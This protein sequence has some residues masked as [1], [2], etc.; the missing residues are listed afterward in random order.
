MNA[1]ERL[2]LARTDAQE[3]RFAQALS[4]YVWF[5]DH[6]LE[7]QESLRV[8][9]LSFALGFWCELAGRYPPARVALQ[10]T[11]DETVRRLENGEESTDLFRDLI[12]INELLGNEEATYE[13][14][15]SINRAN[16]A[17]AARCATMA[18]PAI[19]RAF[20]FALARK[21]VPDPEKSIDNLASA[22][23]HAIS[24]NTRNVK[25]K[26]LVDDLN[27]AIQDYAKH[28]GML[29][30]IVSMTGESEQGNELERQ[31][32]SLVE[33]SGL[34]KAVREEIFRNR[35]IN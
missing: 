5:H 24:W 16:P 13:S 9:R 35:H 8:I 14:F 30:R 32:I 17:F 7:E 22:F 15:R 12:A 29:I 25:T 18:L 20:D 19:V 34:R 3:G 28:V 10:A 31:A 26:E 1:Q 33:T 6:A 21:F 4:G 27:S 23:N 2:R 11:R